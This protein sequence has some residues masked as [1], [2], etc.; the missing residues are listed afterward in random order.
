MARIESFDPTTVPP[1]D[2]SFE[3]LPSGWYDAHVIES[4]EVGTKNDAENCMI[5]VTWELLN[6]EL[7]K[8]R[9]WDRIN[10]KNKNQKAQDIGRRRLIDMQT[11]MNI[12]PI[13]DT[14]T[15]HFIPCAI[16]VG[17]EKDET[18]QYEPKNKVTGIAP[19]GFRPGQEMTRP[20]TMPQRA[21]PAQAQG[22]PQAAPRP[23]VAPAAPPPR[24]AGPRP[25]GS[26]PWSR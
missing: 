6:S 22:A 14:N 8:R 16:R 2:R 7:G 1:S 3:L 5:N 10:Y 25:A 11:A 20:V 17:V 15:M 18:G 13:E 26:L 4:D 24:Q 21:A 19:Y 23:A 12:P 9:V